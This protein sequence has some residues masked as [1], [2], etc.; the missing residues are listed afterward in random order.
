MQLTYY[1]DI[2]T[3]D[4]PPGLNRDN[5]TTSTGPQ[6]WQISWGLKPVCLDLAPRNIWKQSYCLGPMTVEQSFC[7]YRTLL[8][9]IGPRNSISC[10]DQLSTYKK[11]SLNLSLWAP[12]L[13]SRQIVWKDLEVGGDNHRLG[14]VERDHSGIMEFHLPALA[15]SS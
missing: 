9:S 11:E 1:F 7:T 4:D 2:G 3:K 5:H 15:V 6:S 8:P 12:L 14:Q 10:K 13:H